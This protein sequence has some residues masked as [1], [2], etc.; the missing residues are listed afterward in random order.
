MTEKRKVT[1][2]DWNSSKYLK[3]EQDISAYLDAAM[4]YD[5]PELLN[6]ALDN[7]ARARGM[8]EIARRAGVTREGLYASFSKDGNPS[9]RTVSKV[10][11]AFGVRL[12]VVPINPSNK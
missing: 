4:E 9:F 5:D 8:T 12:S 2:S 11:N 7:I 1:V 3:T 10:L 6:L